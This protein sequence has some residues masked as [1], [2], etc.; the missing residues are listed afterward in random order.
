[1]KKYPQLIIQIKAHT[2]SRGRDDFNYILSDKR[3]NA[4]LVWLLKKG[5]NRQRILAIGFG[6]EQLLN[7]CKNGVKCTEKEHLENRRTEFVIV[8]PY[9]IG[10]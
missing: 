1:M 2:D 4:V 8:N 6:E 10:N 7:D 5:I 3:A 9:V